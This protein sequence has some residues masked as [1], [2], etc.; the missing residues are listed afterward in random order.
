[1]EV[2]EHVEAGDIEINVCHF[3]QNQIN[4]FLFQ[5][6]DN[7]ILVNSF[8]VHRGKILHEN[9]DVDYIEIAETEYEVLD[10]EFEIHEIE[11]K[12]ESYQQPNQQGVN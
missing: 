6:Q 11:D 12:M 5:C 8:I 7:V 10:Q 2:V 9:F 3:C 4:T 1:M